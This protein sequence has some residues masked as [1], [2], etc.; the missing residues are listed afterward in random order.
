MTEQKDTIWIIVPVYN[1]KKVLG[2]CIR[3]IFHQTYTDWK[4]MLIDD[5]STD[6]S[7]ALCDKYAAKDSRIQVIHTPNAGPHAARLQGLKQVPQTDYCC[8][9]D[10][11]DELK[12]NALQA[13]YDRAAQTEAD[14]VCGDMERVWNGC[15]VSK[16]K[17][18]PCFAEPR[19]Y[20]KK[21]LIGEVYL[22]C[23]GGG[24]SFPVSLCAKL[25]RAAVLKEVM[26]HLEQG[27]R[28]FAEDLNVTMQ[29]MPKVKRIATIGEVVYRYRIGGGTSRFM[30]TFLD[31]NL[32]MYHLKMKWSDYCTAEDNVKWL[33]GIELKNIIVTYWLMC[34]KNNRYPSG[35]L[36]KEVQIVCA[37]P[38][39]QEALTMLEWDRSGL[40][41]INPLL[42]ARNYDGI[43]TLIRQ[44]VKKDRPKDLLKKIL[45][46]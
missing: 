41:G 46:G 14:V 11:D 31:D 19:V 33:I 9:C 12:P 45:M 39:V 32:L 44:K 7:G 28:C 3:S 26:E 38:E 2:K 5:G 40:P 27:P 1:V 29:L 17:Q 24:G 37:L 30:P 18:I 16:R 21:E 6:G 43:C 36:E 25:Y 10:S 15:V 20:E 22:C 8:F 35:S 4:L 34:A 23:F 13:M 42:I